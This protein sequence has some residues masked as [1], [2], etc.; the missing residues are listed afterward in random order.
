MQSETLASTLLQQTTLEEKIGQLNPLLVE[1][2][3][4]LAAE[5]ATARGINW[6]LAPMLV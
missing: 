5:E 4:R 1:Q 3:A 2:C 6:T